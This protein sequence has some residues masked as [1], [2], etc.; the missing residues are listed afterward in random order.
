[1]S[2]IYKYI[3]ITF[4]SSRIILVNTECQDNNSLKYY[5][6]LLA[7]CADCPLNSISVSPTACACLSGFIYN[8]EFKGLKNGCIACPTNTINDS[9]SIFC[10][11]CNGTCNCND[12]RINVDRDESGKILPNKFCTQCEEGFM[13]NESKNRCIVRSEGFKV[14]GYQVCDTEYEFLKN[15]CAQ[16]E[17]LT[18]LRTKFPENDFSTITYVMLSKEKITI[19]TS[20]FFHQDIYNN[21]ILC[22]QNRILSS[23]NKILNIC[24][25]TMHSENPI[26]CI[27]YEYIYKLISNTTEMISDLYIDPSMTSFNEIYID[28]DSKNMQLFVTI[29]NAEGVYEGIYP[30]V[31]ELSLCD[32]DINKLTDGK[33]FF[34]TCHKNLKLLYDKPKPKY[35]ELSVLLANGKLSIIPIVTKLNQGSQDFS[36]KNLSNEQIMRRFSLYENYL[37]APNDNDKRLLIFAKKGHLNVYKSSQGLHQLFYYLEYEIINIE[38]ISSANLELSINYMDEKIPIE[39]FM[40]A[41][42][43]VLHIFII[44][45]AIF[46]AYFWNKLDPSF[47][48]ESNFTIPKLLRYLLILIQTWLLIIFSFTSFLA[49]YFL[50]FYKVAQNIIFYFPHND[51]HTSLFIAFKIIVVILGICAIFVQIDVLIMLISR[52]VVLIDWERRRLEV[53]LP[54]SLH[55]EST[56]NHSTKKIEIHSGWRSILVANEFF[57]LAISRK[58]NILLTFI[59]FGVFNTTLGLEKSTLLNHGDEYNE[60]TNYIL[61]YGYKTL[62]L[63]LI[64]FSQYFVIKI[65]DTMFGSKTENYLDFLTFSN[66]SLFIFDTKYHCFYIHGGNNAGSSEGNFDDLQKILTKEA[67]GYLSKRGLIESDVTELQCFELF[68]PYEL[69]NNIEFLK[70]TKNNGR[71]EIYNNKNQFENDNEAK[72]FIQEDDN[73]SNYVQDISK[74]NWKNYPINTAE[75]TQF[76][77]KRNIQ[78]ILKQII[79]R[80]SRNKDKCMDKNILQRITG[81]PNFDLKYF[82]GYPIFYRDEKKNFLKLMFVGQELSNFIY[83]VVI[84]LALNI[85]IGNSLICAFLVYLLDLFRHLILEKYFKKKF[86][87]S[88]LVKEAFLN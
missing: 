14:T 28:N 44:I 64:G 71:T 19:N 69:S 88:T 51:I 5:D 23:C 32:Y 55:I 46:R 80:I 21:V 8:T 59:I 86:S 25:S 60:N 41:I 63:L 49:V 85:L 30:L 62:I 82:K 79:D 73:G 1:M 61:D 72:E 47:N 24:A 11:S 42:F 6:I 36:L 77:S 26:F 18:D 58:I 40:I 9:T 83:L 27:L 4:L 52:D 17:L 7:N 78:H 22:L 29:Y 81:L 33:N 16:T 31:N 56:Y 50:L 84:F 68:L 67:K 37:T 39:T 54:K 65:R 34:T 48:N 3:L 76:E 74:K 10:M 66:V 87:H 53:D 2:N 57:E 20:T 35:Y 43:I 38:E 15:I 12:N 70:Q 45:I 13:P 75:Y